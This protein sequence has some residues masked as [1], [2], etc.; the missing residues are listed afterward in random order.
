M[1]SR[2]FETL[3]RRALAE[4]Q[5]AGKDRPTQTEEAVRAVLQAFPDMTA[6]EA[7]KAV[8]LVRRS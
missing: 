1:P 4:S 7:L 8:N 3:I 6:N 5:A 2:N